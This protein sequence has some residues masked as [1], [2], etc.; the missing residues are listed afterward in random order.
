MAIDHIGF[1]KA[2]KN[3]LVSH[4]VNRFVKINCGDPRDKTQRHLNQG[5]TTQG[6]KLPLVTDS[7]ILVDST[8]HKSFTPVNIYSGKIQKLCKLSETSLPCSEKCVNI[9]VYVTCF[10]GFFSFFDLL[11]IC[12]GPAKM[13]FSICKLTLRRNNI[14]NVSVGPGQKLFEYTKT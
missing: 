11:T 4:R 7:L 3:N 12:D 1:L 14:A 5:A 6:G 13:A 10:F 2:N 9:S 8:R